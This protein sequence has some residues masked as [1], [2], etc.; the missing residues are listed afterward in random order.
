VV[1]RHSLQWLR[2]GAICAAVVVLS[3]GYVLVVNA[4]LPHSN[5]TITVGWSESQFNATWI[6]ANTSGA[7]GY[8]VRSNESISVNANGTVQ[9][10]GIVTAQNFK[11]PAWN[12]TN[13][14]Y[15]T[16]TV[17]SSSTYLAVRI[18]VWTGSM[19]PHDVVLSTFNDR[20]WHPIYV[21]LTGMLGYTGS[22]QPYLIELGWFV[23]QQPVGPNPS[24]QFEDL[25]LVSLRG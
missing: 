10:G 19:S 9:P 5:L 15:L 22:L 21:D 23:V 3:A 25:A 13:Y 17:R 6:E 4:V 2:V 16:V 18:M 20:S 14:P 8:L 7:A 12:L 11:L 1:T 24:V